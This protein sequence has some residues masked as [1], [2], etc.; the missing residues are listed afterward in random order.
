MNH[1]KKKLTLKH[2]VPIN[3]IWKIN[4]ETLSPC[5]HVGISKYEG[6]QL[7]GLT[8][9]VTCFIQKNS[10]L[11]YVFVMLTSEL[12]C[13]QLCNI[14][15]A[16][17]SG[18]P[19]L[20]SFNFWVKFFIQNVVLKVARRKISKFFACSTLFSCVFDESVYRSAL[21]PQ[22][23]PCFEKLLVAHLNIVQY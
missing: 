2:L 18:R 13:F 10:F 20:F 22:N 21:I 23:L 7:S 5:V 8:K 1:Q 11:S 15:H 3:R 19:R 16:T 4:Q 6:T 9:N 17:Q 12:C 14:R